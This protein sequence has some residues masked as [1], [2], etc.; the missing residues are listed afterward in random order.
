MNR[1]EVDAEA[2]VPDVV[3]K[4][5]DNPGQPATI[6]VSAD[7]AL[8]LTANEFRA[9]AAAAERN[10]VALAI[11]TDD[12]LRRQLA[13]MFGVPIALPVQPPSEMED[14][15][16]DPSDQPGEQAIE[17][18]EESDRDYV[19]PNGAQAPVVLDDMPEEEPLEPEAARSEDVEPREPVEVAPRAVRQR[20][21]R[22]KPFAALLGLAVV[23]AAAVGLYW[24]FFTTATIELTLRREPVSA[25][26]A[27]VVVQPGGNAPDDGSTAIPAEP[28]TFDLSTTLTRAAT[29]VEAVGIDPARG[30]LVLRNP[31][32]EPVTIAAG[33][34]FTSFEG[35]VYRF[36]SEV[37][38]PA[39]EDNGETPGET[40][41][42]VVSAQPGAAGNREL[43]TLT[44]QLDNGIYYSNRTEPIAGGT[45]EET[46]IVTQED[47]DALRDEASKVLLDSAAAADLSDGR[48]LLPSSISSGDGTFVFSQEVGDAADSVSVE[49]SMRFTALAYDPGALRDAAMAELTQVVPPGYALEQSTPT[50]SSQQ[51]A[52][53][54]NGVTQVTATVSGSARPELPEAD[55]QMIADEVAGMDEN[56]AFDYL[57]GLP[58][59]ERVEI[60]YAPDWL[61]DRIPS[62]G[63]RIEVETR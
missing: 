10:Q 16:A 34:E 21:A 24:F 46:I 37:T 63:G 13:T 62:S 19:S 25:A 57:R 42:T 29:G 11:D 52:A 60:S 20:R 12:P 33:T 53:G 50:F 43:G 14:A 54:E 27:Y 18:S 32:P 5:R 49:A 51:E 35:A 61:P 31:G 3:A 22:W 45:E 1:I 6:Y 2:T 28:V 48:L 44:G 38:V 47:L 30:V 17:G 59:V 8:L 7:T 4:L 55:R 26:I 58:Y 15:E 9:I 36:E 39:A 40:T 56:E 23:I 41:A